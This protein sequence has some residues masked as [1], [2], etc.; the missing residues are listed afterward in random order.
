MQNILLPPNYTNFNIIY[1]SLNM[2]LLDK[3]YIY[4]IIFDYMKYLLWLWNM[5]MD[6]WHESSLEC[7]VVQLLPRGHVLLCWL[8]Y[9]IFWIHFMENISKNVKELCTT[10]YW[11]ISFIY[12][13]LYNCLVVST[14]CFFLFLYLW[15]FLSVTFSN[16]PTK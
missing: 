15:S 5:S 9:A 12:L 10:C 7:R 3:L 1:N 6:V 14:G 8:C 11:Q 4:E 13:H 16:Q 2:G